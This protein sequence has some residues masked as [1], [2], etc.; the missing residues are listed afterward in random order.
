MSWEFVLILLVSGLGIRYGLPWEKFVCQM[1][2]LLPF[3][4]A[5]MQV[6][7]QR[8]EARQEP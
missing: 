1:A 5:Y 7:W 8:L 4:F 2:L 6:H 3:P